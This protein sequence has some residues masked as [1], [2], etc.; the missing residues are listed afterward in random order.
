MKDWMKYIKKANACTYDY[1]QR[2]NK[3][4]YILTCY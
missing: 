3:C 4:K 2:G 1:I